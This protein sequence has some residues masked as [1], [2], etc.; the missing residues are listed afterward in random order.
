MP[1]RAPRPGSAAWRRLA[2]GAVAASGLWLAGAC[3]SVAQEIVAARFAEPTARYAH[4]VL[5]DALEW[6][7]LEWTLSDGR[8]LRA[9]L[10]ETM[11]FEDLA[12][13]L[14]DVDGDG[15]SEIVVVETA[16]DRGARLAVWG[17]SGRIAA[18]PFIGRANRWLAPVAAVD[19]DGDGRIEIALVDR[20]HLAKELQLWRIAGEGLERVASYGGVSNHQIGWDVIIGGARDCG[21]GPELV[22]GSGDWLELVALRFDGAEFARSSLGPWSA[23]AARRALSCG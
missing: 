19:L 16:L 14:W 7:A 17:A 11:V 15:L 2:R 18:G 8:S 22:L 20:P 21:D 4:G 13:R 9:A 5:G 10:P 1:A 3:G 12:P 23:E 6:A